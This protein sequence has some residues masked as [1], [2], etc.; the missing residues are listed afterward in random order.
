MRPYIVISRRPSSNSISPR[1]ARKNSA[2]GMR[3][4]AVW[5]STV[6]QS[7]LEICTRSS[8]LPTSGSEKLTRPP[9]ESAP[10][11]AMI[12][13]SLNWQNASPNCSHDCQVLPSLVERLLLR[14]QV[15]FAVTMKNAA[16]VGIGPISMRSP[17]VISSSCTFGPRPPAATIAGSFKSPG[18]AF[19]W[20]A[21]H[22]KRNPDVNSRIMFGPSAKLPQASAPVQRC[23]Q[24]NAPPIAAYR[25]SSR[26]Y[27]QTLPCMS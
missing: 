10:G 21:S 25:P 8:D 14:T 15:P 18:R 2:S 6:S 27:C 4:L 23:G 16:L 24:L 13:P 20:S 7:S 22:A 5:V 1:A 3:M 26:Q 12:V 11:T 17:T 19:P 9:L